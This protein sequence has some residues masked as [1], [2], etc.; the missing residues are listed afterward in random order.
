MGKKGTSQRPAWEVDDLSGRSKDGYHLVRKRRVATL[1]QPEIDFINLVAE[2]GAATLIVGDK[3]KAKYIIDRIRIKII[4]WGYGGAMGLSQRENEIVG[5]MVGK[6]D[7]KRTNV[8]IEEVA[9]K[10]ENI[11]KFGV[12]TRRKI[13][14]DVV[15]LKSAIG[16]AENISE[17]KPL[18]ELARE[19]MN[20]I[21]RKQAEESGRVYETPNRDGG[22]WLYPAIDN[23]PEIRVWESREAIEEMKAKG[24]PGGE[25]D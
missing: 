16:R 13:D 7:R 19:S 3:G 14:E 18:A 22:W 8:A 25:V 24:T 12:W 15:G 1:S 2:K 5:W 9:Y 20:K 23:S 6:F 11:I 17:D 21:R 10:K 4:E